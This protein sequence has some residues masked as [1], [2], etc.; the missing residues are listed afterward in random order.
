MPSLFFLVYPP[1]KS[2]DL[3]LAE[4]EGQWDVQVQAHGEEGLTSFSR[5]VYFREAESLRG[6]AS[7]GSI[8]LGQAKGASN[9]PP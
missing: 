5:I 3:G 1:L 8:V 7:P 4:L 9:Q 2:Q 6:I